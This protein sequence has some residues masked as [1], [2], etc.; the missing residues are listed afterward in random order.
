MTATTANKPA[1]DNIVRISH[2]DADPVSGGDPSMSAE[3]RPVTEVPRAGDVADAI[4]GFDDRSNRTAT[5]AS[6]PDGAR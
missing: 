2:Q 5:H 4:S 1:F 3:N 6:S